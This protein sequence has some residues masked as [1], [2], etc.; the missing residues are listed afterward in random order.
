MRGAVAGLTDAE[1]QQ[2]A[3]FSEMQAA[4]PGAQPNP[5]QQAAFDAY[6]RHYRDFATTGRLQTIR[7]C[8]VDYSG[9]WPEVNG[10]SAGPYLDGSW[11]VEGIGYCL[12]LSRPTAQKWQVLAVNGRL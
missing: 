9:K 8:P 12:D 7:G 1:M 5:A 3:D 4:D 6:E 10:C 11:W 2:V